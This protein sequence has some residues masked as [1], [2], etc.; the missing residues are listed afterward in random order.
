MLQVGNTFEK[1]GVSF[2]VLDIFVYEN[3]KYVLISSEKDGISYEFYELI[4][5]P[6]GGCKLNMVT[7]ENLKLN[8]FENFE[9]RN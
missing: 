5:S 1:N 4:D 7:D 2:C 8:L 3:V 6:Q 9:R